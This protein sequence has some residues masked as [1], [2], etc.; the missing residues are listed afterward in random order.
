[1]FNKRIVSGRSFKTV[2]LEINPVGMT[3]ICKQLAILYAIN[4]FTNYSYSND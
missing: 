2:A 3:K 4:K 1:M